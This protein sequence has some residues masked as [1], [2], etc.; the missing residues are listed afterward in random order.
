MTKVKIYYYSLSLCMNENECE[1]REIGLHQKFHE[2]F[3]KLK[4][5][6]KNGF[7]DNLL[8]ERLTKVMSIYSCK[9]MKNEDV[10]FQSNEISVEIG[11][12]GKESKIV[13]K[14]TFSISHYQNREEAQMHPF[15][16]ALFYNEDQRK[17]VLAIEAIG[18]SK[19]KDIVIDILRNVISD[20]SIK[21]KLLPIHPMQ[22][23]KKLFGK[24]KIT[25][26]KLKKIYPHND[27]ANS[28]NGMPFYSQNVIVRY[29]QPVFQNLSNFVKKIFL[30]SSIDE[31][32]GIEQGKD[33]EDIE[34]VIQDGSTKRN[35]KYSS[36]Y[37][38]ESFENIT[39][40]VEFA[41]NGFPSIASV[42]SK[43]FESVI[44]YLKKLDLITGD[45]TKDMLKPEYIY[46]DRSVQE[47]EDNN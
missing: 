37:N 43:M 41:N 4:D 20:T 28:T 44:F 8:K 14:N 38:I 36:I 45:I 35:V 24:G 22:I 31:I 27:I 6:K 16:F 7:E 15:C 33:V 17:G 26:I 19:N 23:A 39:E 2:Y 42:F 18:H 34:F 5:N 10:V 40:S 3:C 30:G 47:S 11:K 1:F 32:I 13:N 46:K 12:Y 25:E 29:Q 21:I 9:Y